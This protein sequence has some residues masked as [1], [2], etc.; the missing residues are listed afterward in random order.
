[1][2]NIDFL[3]IFVVIVSVLLT[4]VSF[5]VPTTHWLIVVAFIFG[6]IFSALQ[7]ILE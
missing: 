6:A 1:M 7:E 2:Q 3:A 5:V 4:V